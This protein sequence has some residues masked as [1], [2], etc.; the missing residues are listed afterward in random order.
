MMASFLEKPDTVA[1]SLNQTMIFCPPVVNLAV[2]L[3]A[4]CY[5]ISTAPRFWRICFVA[6]ADIDIADEKMLP[7][8]VELY[9]A[10]FRPNAKSTF[11]NVGS[12]DDTTRSR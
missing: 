8:A 5:T 1:A 4:D 11:S 6:Q 3:A 7:R 12:W 9:N 10:I 2:T